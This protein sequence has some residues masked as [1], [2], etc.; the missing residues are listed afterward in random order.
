[1]ALEKEI[2]TY[3][4]ELPKL[5]EHQGK[6]VVIFDNEVAGIYDSYSDALKVGYEKRGL[7]PFFVKKIE[8]MEQAQHFTRDLVI[9]CHT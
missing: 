5:I 9:P 1:M 2:E 7:E 8:V 4:R 6:F 3:N